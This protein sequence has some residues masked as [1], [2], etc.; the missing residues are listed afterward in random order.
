MSAAAIDTAVVARLAGDATL[1]ALVPDGIWF[2]AAPQNVTAFGLVVPVSATEDAVFGPPGARRAWEENV[3]A[4]V[5]VCQGKSASAAQDA[6]ARIDALLVD[7]DLAVAGYTCMLLDRSARI[8]LA[9]V[10]A[11]DPNIQWQQQGGQYRVRMTP[12]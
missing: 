1:A 10:D 6:A 2:G 7:H 5:A 9:T 4:I 12:V 8:A 11:V 3:Y